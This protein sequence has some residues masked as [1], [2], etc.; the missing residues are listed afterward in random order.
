MDDDDDEEVVLTRS[1]MSI[2]SRT[3]AR[4]L[5]NS[6][7]P[8]HEFMGKVRELDD[9]WSQAEYSV[10]RRLYEAGHAFTNFLN[11][12]AEM[13]S[14]ANELDEEASRSMVQRSSS[15]AAVTAE[16]AVAVGDDILAADIHAFA[17]GAS[18]GSNYSSGAPRQGIPAPSNVSPLSPASH[19]GGQVRGGSSSSSGGGGGS[20]PVPAKSHSTDGNTKPDFDEYPIDEADARTLFEAYDTGSDGFLNEAD[21]GQCLPIV[22][23]VLAQ[24]GLLEL[25]EP[26]SSAGSVHGHTASGGNRNTQASYAGAL[27][28]GA[29]SFSSALQPTNG[30]AAATSPSSSGSAP[31]TPHA[32]AAAA[33]APRCFAAAD[34]HRRRKLSFSDFATWLFKEPLPGAEAYHRVNSSQETKGSTAALE[35]QCAALAATLAAERQEHAFVVQK[36]IATAAEDQRLL[37]A[38][39]SKCAALEAENSSL[40]QEAAAVQEDVDRATQAID[41]LSQELA[42]S[43]EQLQEQQL[44]L[45]QRDEELAQSRAS[46]SGQ[47]GAAAAA[48][49]AQV[50]EAALIDELTALRDALAAAETENAA[51]MQATAG[52]ATENSLL[53]QRNNNNSGAVI[54][55]SS[56]T[57]PQA[58]RPLS[59]TSPVQAALERASP[60]GPW[61]AKVQLFT[62]EIKMPRSTF[63]FSFCFVLFMYM[64][65]RVSCIKCHFSLLSIR[66]ISSVLCTLA[67]IL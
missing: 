40:S 13:P 2:G 15:G 14:I 54:L 57:S 6:P 19:S 21:F 56:P 9:K 63:L 4:L 23:E 22:F 60:P 67:A 7:P 31:V 28:P 52:V 62:F 24:T 44:Q 27:N 17:S 37:E 32:A 58:P 41:T 25:P 30:G 34:L 53:A 10:T 43:Q 49:Q 64:P 61:A 12:T 46:D 51:L 59:P 1:P 47:G 50:K 55:A 11:E 3:A 48:A 36:F 5:A 42:V 66:V 39:E 16:T 45:Q 65:A 33:A 26:S 35:A 18:P 20:C 8:P 29:R 38:A